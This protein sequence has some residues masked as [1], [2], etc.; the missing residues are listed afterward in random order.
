[1][2]I[3]AAPYWTPTFRRNGYTRKVGHGTQHLISGTWVLGPQYDQ[4]G[5]GTRD[6]LIGN[7]NPG[8]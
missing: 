3:K 5:S 4:V 8:P 2:L 6:P 1:M 7:R